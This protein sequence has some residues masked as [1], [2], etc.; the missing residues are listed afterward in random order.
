MSTSSTELERLIETAGGRLDEPRRALFAE[1][2][3]HFLLGLD[4]HPAG[5]ESMLATLAL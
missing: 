4:S 5:G 2:A 1:F 3:A